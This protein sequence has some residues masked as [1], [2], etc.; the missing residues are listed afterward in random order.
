VLAGRDDRVVCLLL[1]GRRGAR[2]HQGGGPGDTDDPAAAA[3]SGTGC[4]L[5]AQAAEGIFVGFAVSEAVAVGA[6]EVELAH[7]VGLGAVSVGE[8]AVALVADHV[9]HIGAGRD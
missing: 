4:H 5:V 6:F 2:R 1:G 8:A 9:R 7:P 3:A